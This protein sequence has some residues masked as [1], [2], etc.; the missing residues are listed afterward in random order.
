MALFIKPMEG[1][2]FTKVLILSQKIIGQKCLP[3]KKTKCGGVLIE[4][5]MKITNKRTF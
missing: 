1:K 4:L 3:Y 5:G 2:T